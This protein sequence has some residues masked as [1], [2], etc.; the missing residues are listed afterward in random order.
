MCQGLIES[1]G[2]TTTKGASQTG[3]LF[4]ISMLT[5][6]KAGTHDGPAPLE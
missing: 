3:H 1:S 4:Y 2:L 5:K 6:E